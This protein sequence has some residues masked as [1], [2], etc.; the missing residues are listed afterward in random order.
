MFVG[1]G[2]AD[3]PDEDQSPSPPPATGPYVITRSEPGRSWSY[4]R[5]P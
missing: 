2:A 4:E 3:T 1:S 5:N